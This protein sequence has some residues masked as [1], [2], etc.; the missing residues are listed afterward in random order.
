MDTKMQPT[1]DW[2]IKQN[3]IIDASSG[4]IIPGWKSLVKETTSGD[5]KVLH[6]AKESYNPP[7]IAEFQDYYGQMAEI[8]GFERT[9]FQ[10]WNGGKKIFGYLKNNQEN[11][12]INGNKIDDYLLIGVGF[13][14][15]CAFFVGSVNCLL[16]CQNQFGN[17]N[18][19]WKFNNTKSRE[20]KADELLESFDQ[21]MKVRNL[22]FDAFHKFQ[23]VKI[24][25]KL[26]NE[27]K[28]TIMNMKAHETVKDLGPQRQ[29]QY[30]QLS[31]AINTD[32]KLHGENLF[33]LFNGITRHS[34][35]NLT[36]KHQERNIFGNVSTGELRHKMN[37]EAFNFCQDL[38]FDGQRVLS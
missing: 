20:I 5:S 16:V 32:T 34:T 8:T 22:I 26:I 10:Q 38:A 18:R 15:D 25:Q 37:K 1:L 30:I 11:F 2:E 12:D 19:T 13:T 7:S 28:H 35:H 17:I 14:G 23:D 4:I 33:G 9:G 36:H 24:D 3:K 31:S 29:S 27:C 21:H 6:V